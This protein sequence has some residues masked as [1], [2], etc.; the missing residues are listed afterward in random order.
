MRLDLYKSLYR[1]LIKTLC[2]QTSFQLLMALS[3]FKFEMHVSNMVDEIFLEELVLVN[4]VLS[5]E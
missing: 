2:N 1:L 5:H 4:N 3:H